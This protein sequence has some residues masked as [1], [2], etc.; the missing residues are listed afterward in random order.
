[1]GDSWIKGTILSLFKLWNGN[2]KQI[3][4]RVCKENP[5][6]DFEEVSAVAE[7]A[8]LPL[9]DFCMLQM[10]YEVAAHCSSM[11]VEGE[12]GNPTHA[13][14]MDWGALCLRGLSCQLVLT[15]GGESLYKASTWAGYMGCLT[16]VRRGAFSITVNYRHSNKGGTIKDNFDA[17]LAG[18]WPVGFLVRHLLEHPEAT[19]KHVHTC[20]RTSST[21]QQYDHTDPMWWL[22][23]GVSRLH[24]HPDHA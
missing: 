13:R 7:L 1:M 20:R 17:G 10:A 24:Q 2:F 3:A 15:R 11:I 22:F 19:H 18:A 9:E 16:G 12:D 21:P 5:A 6:I 14:T 23:A 4:V 8:G